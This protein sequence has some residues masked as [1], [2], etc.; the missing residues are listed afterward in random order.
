MAEAELGPEIIGAVLAWTREQKLE[1]VAVLGLL[2]LFQAKIRGV[3]IPTQETVS[4]E[5]LRPSLL[6]WL[7]IKSL[8]KDSIGAP[9]VGEMH[10]ETAPVRFEANPF[11]LKHAKWLVPPVYLERATRIDAKDCPGF[12]AQ[13]KFEW[14]RVVE[15]TGLGLLTPRADFWTRQDDDHLLCL[16]LPLSEAYR[17]AYLRAVA[18][19]ADK[20]FVSADSALWLAAQTCP[21]DLGLWQV[22]PGRPPDSWPR[23]EE[24][25]DSIDTL[26]GKLTGELAA[27]WQRQLGEE[28]LIAEASGRVLETSSSAY[29]V[30]IVGV[31]Q[32]CNGPSEPEIEGIIDRG[33][34]TSIAEETDDPMVFDGGYGRKRAGDYE[35]GHDDWSIWRLA[36]PTNPNP[37][38]RWQWWRFMRGVWLPSPFLA[39]RRFEFRCT[40][41]GVII[42]ENG[43]ELARWTDWTYHLR[44]MTTGNLTPSSGQMLVI[45]RSVVD[46]ESA[47]LGGVYA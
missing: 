40:K 19:A 13:W 6:S 46:H 22:P 26:P 30:E 38:P 3:E 31:I 35:E 15:L 1:S 2:A 43:R 32:A 24:T 9:A 34:K 12:L 18:W 39:E 47:K 17:S 29:D 36:A 16:D 25:Q 44:E 8:Y 27:M 37:L 11:F 7:I 4:R 10:S 20:Q 28:W 33:H 21:I 45:H 42:E 5:L 23:C 14:T 41:E